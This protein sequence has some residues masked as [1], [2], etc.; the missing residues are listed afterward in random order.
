MLLFFGTPPWC[1]GV[2]QST[3]KTT[4][5]ANHHPTSF[6]PFFADSGRA[7]DGDFLYGPYCPHLCLISSPTECIASSQSCNG[8]LERRQ[9]T[10]SEDRCAGRGEKSCRR[11]LLCSFFHL[12]HTVISCLGYDAMIIRQLG[13]L[14]GGFGV[15]YLRVVAL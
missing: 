13:S 3:A 7:A 9:L 2:A 14:Y 12:C 4:A 5:L 8:A 6:I 15:G 1:S 10:H 11:L